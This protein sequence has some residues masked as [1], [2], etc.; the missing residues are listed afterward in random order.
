M[1]DVAAVDATAPDGVTERSLDARHAGFLELAGSELDRSYRLAGLILGDATD[2]EDAVQDALL[3]AW[4][5]VATLRDPA[6]FQAWFDRILVNGCRDRV[7]RRRIV[8]FVPIDP[9][10]DVAA[11]GDPFRAV[12]ARDELLGGLDALSTAERAVVVLHYWA[13][14]SV[15]Q[16]SARLGWPTGTIKSRLHRARRVLRDHLDARSRGVPS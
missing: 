1:T 12:L 15:E 9:T 14:L 6:M 16:I 5:S 4:R 11:E 10:T 2:A 8:R 3:Q 13:D 7:R